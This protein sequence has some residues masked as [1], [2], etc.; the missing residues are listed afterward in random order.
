MVMLSNRPP[1]LHH[2]IE[3]MSTSNK[4]E[5]AGPSAYEPLPPV[6]ESLPSFPYPQTS[7]D[8]AKNAYGC[9]LTT[10]SPPLRVLLRGS[11]PTADIMRWHQA[12][13]FV[14]SGAN[15]GGGEAGFNDSHKQWATRV[16]EESKGLEMATA[17]PAV[18][19]HQ[20]MVSS[21]RGLI[22]LGYLSVVGP[23][24]ATY[25]RRNIH[26]GMPN[27]LLSA[28]HSPNSPANTH[29]LSLSLFLPP[30]LFITSLHAGSGIV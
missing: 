11:Y 10:P 15:P 16:R 26:I 27:A 22:C 1:N 4:D 12:N 19:V 14:T 28:F 3:Q 21:F 2:T 30:P 24:R 9:E 7:L 5:N 23:C 29:A 18:V 20:G 13:Q 6:L 8:A 25:A 17:L